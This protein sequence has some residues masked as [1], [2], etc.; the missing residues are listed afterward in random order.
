MAVGSSGDVSVPLACKGQLSV[1]LQR[2]SWLWS[3]VC[4]VSVGHRLDWCF[5]TRALPACIPQGVRTSKAPCC[6]HAG[7]MRRL[8]LY[9]LN[10]DSTEDTNTHY[11]PKI[12]AATWNLL[13]LMVRERETKGKPI[14]ICLVGRLGFLTLDKRGNTYDW[15]NKWEC[16]FQRGVKRR[17]W[18]LNHSWQCKNTHRNSIFSRQQLFNA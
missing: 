15:D 10:R 5:A 13:L 2:S 17:I 3:C 11:S 1:S 6:T 12:D 4:H 18:S 7:K 9:H 14:C 8:C 16:V